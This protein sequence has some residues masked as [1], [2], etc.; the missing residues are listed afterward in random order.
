MVKFHKQQKMHPIAIYY[1][2]T[3][4]QQ[5]IRHIAWASVIC[6]PQTPVSCAGKL[7]FHTACTFPTGT[8]FLTSTEMEIISRQSSSTDF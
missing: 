6:E 7:P 4:I 3:Q 5:D 2:I 1:E 8:D